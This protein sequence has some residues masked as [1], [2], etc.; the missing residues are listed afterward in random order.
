MKWVPTFRPVCV[1]CN[2]K[3]LSREGWPWHG[4][5]QERYGSL[6]TDRRPKSSWRLRMPVLQSPGRSFRRTRWCVGLDCL[7]KPYHFIL[8]PRLL[9]VFCIAWC[10]RLGLFGDLQ[11]WE[12][13][14]PVMVQACPWQRPVRPSG[15][16]A[17]REMERAIIHPTI[18]SLAR[19]LTG[20]A[21]AQAMFVMFF[22]RER[23]FVL[24]PDRDLCAFGATCR[25][26]LCMPKSQFQLPSLVSGGSRLKI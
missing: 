14:K 5:L 2:S 12:R 19:A 18:Q 1:L 26:C 23:V 25:L 20:L 6:R 8:A 7:L 22:V 17:V 13:R 21:E 24:S 15:A 10:R 11:D 9:E 4:S 3:H 16:S